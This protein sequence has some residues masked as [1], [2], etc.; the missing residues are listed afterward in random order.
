MENPVAQ[1][2]KFFIWKLV[3]NGLDVQSNRLSHHLIFD[4]T[5]L[6]CGMEPE[7]GHHAMVRCTFASALRH[8]LRQ[9]WNLPDDSAFTYTGPGWV[10]ALL[11]SANKDLRA[12]LMLLFW[13]IWHHR[14]DN[15]FG[16]GQCPISV[17]VIFL[18]NY[19]RPLKLCGDTAPPVNAKGKTPCTSNPDFLCQNDQRTIQTRYPWTP[20]PLGWIKLNVDAGFDPIT[21][22]A[23]LGFVAWNHLSGVVLSGWTSNHLCSSVEEAENL[24]ALIGI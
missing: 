5:C 22:Q 12:K 2:V 11:D 6:I 17:S 24:A 9:S 8:A 19:L 15:V 1:K 13:R 10:L 21:R 14:N 16:N 7:D 18:E 3:R 4:A 23:G 20:P